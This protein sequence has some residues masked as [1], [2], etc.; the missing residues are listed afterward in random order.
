MESIQKMRDLMFVGLRIS[1]NFL[2]KRTY[3]T[4][5][6]IYVM[7]FV[8]LICMNPDLKAYYNENVDYCSAP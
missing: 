6:I 7:D 1:K 3:W 5:L 8:T 2:R 4:Y